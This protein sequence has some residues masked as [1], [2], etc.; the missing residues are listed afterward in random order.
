MPLLELL[1]LLFREE[2]NNNQ[3]NHSHS[4]ECIALG[5]SE[6]DDEDTME[7]EIPLNFGKYVKITP[8]RSLK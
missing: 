5:D 6:E 8:W 2:I 1:G 3:S 7:S 4:I